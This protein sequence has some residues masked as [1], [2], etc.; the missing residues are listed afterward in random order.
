MWIFGTC[1]IY[2][3]CILLAF[4]LSSFVWFFNWVLVPYC[5]TTQEVQK[6]KNGVYIIWNST[7]SVFGP[8]RFLRLF[9]PDSFRTREI[10]SLVLSPSTL[11]ILYKS[12]IGEVRLVSFLTPG[13]GWVRSFPFHPSDLKVETFRYSSVGLWWWYHLSQSLPVHPRPW[14]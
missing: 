10:V 5:N 1:N 12:V 11:S 3:Y 6:I 2:T 7:S 9:F 14:N 4:H 13:W 8:L